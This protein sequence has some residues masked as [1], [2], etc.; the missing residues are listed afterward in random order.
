M[1]SKI[2]GW[3]NFLILWVFYVL[4]SIGVVCFWRFITGVVPGTAEV[5]VIMSAVY[6]GGYLAK[7][8]YQGGGWRFW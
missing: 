4:I 3:L 5:I 6:A 2:P 1:I 7:W 8:R